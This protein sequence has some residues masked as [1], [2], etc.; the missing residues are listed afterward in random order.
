MTR[1]E[2]GEQ[3]AAREA[4]KALRDQAAPLSEG[5]AMGLPIAK[6]KQD[7]KRVDGYAEGR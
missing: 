2:H 6:G 5:Q 3:K 7:G 1:S 4:R